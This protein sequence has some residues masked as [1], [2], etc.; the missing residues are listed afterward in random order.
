MDVN[1]TESMVGLVEGDMWDSW[2]ISLLTVRLAS[3]SKTTGGFDVVVVIVEVRSHS[4][5]RFSAAM[6]SRM[7]WAA[8]NMSRRVEI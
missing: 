1:K 7:F 4:S 5:T 6:R 2:L 3:S 8:W